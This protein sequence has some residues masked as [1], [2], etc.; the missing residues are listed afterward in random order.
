M[1]NVIPKGIRSEVNHH[2]HQDKK[3][4]RD[5]HHLRRHAGVVWHR[6]LACRTDATT[7]PRIRELQLRA[8][9]APQRDP[10]R[11]ALNLW[12]RCATIRLAREIGR[13]AKLMC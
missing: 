1:L 6:R 7:A 5:F 10:Q 9:P 12:E 8:L 3:L 11:A 13:S 2:E 4:F